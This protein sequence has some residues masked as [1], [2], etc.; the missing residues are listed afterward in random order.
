[1]WGSDRRCPG[2]PISPQASPAEA[3][4]RGRPA[5]LG[6]ITPATSRVQSNSRRSALGG[7]GPCVCGE[8]SSRVAWG[9]ATR[10][11]EDWAAVES[12]L[13]QEV[14]V[15]IAGSGTRHSGESWAPLCRTLCL[16][17]AGALPRDPLIGRP[18]CKTLILNLPQPHGPP[19]PHAHATLALSAPAS[20]SRGPGRVGPGRAPGPGWRRPGSPGSLHG[21]AIRG[22]RPEAG[23][24]VGGN[25]VI[26]L[27]PPA[28][29]QDQDQR[30]S[31]GISRPVL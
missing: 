13:N 4:V 7:K 20:H 25:S 24:R 14:L 1:M 17:A 28:H 11:G 2:R 18:R 29:R 30:A 27:P 10:G 15:Q 6:G 8:R 12:P 5:R 31:G 23:R 21:D 3:Q 19:S 16:W 22:K 9:L 26:G